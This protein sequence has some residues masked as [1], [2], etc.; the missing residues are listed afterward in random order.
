MTTNSIRRAALRLAAVTAVA[1]TAM[2]AGT[3]E[4]AAQEQFFS[5]CFYDNNN[6]NVFVG[7]LSVGFQAYP[8]GRPGNALYYQRVGNT[9]RYVGQ[10]GAIY[11][12]FQNGDAT[13]S[14][15]N[16]TIRLYRC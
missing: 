6:V 10:T 3:D 5:Y 11:A 12:L 9:H 2:G 8:A 4:A 15:G 13:W 14:D 1:L 16:Q 7:D